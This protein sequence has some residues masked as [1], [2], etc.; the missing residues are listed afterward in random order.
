MK[1]IL[2]I[3]LLSATL[4]ALLSSCRNPNPEDYVMMDDD[5]RKYFDV[6]RSDYTGKTIEIDKK[7]EVTDEAVNA[8]I[9]EV[10]WE[11]RRTVDKNKEIAE[12]DFV[13]FYVRGE[14]NGVTLPDGDSTNY[15]TGSP[16]YATLG[17]TPM[18]EAIKNALLGKKVADYSLSRMFAGIVSK[19]QNIMISYFGY[20]YGDDG[21][22]VEYIYRDSQYVKL[23][24][25]DSKLYLSAVGET[26]G[27][28]YSYQEKTVIDGVEREV[29][30][31][32]LVDCII[33][34]EVAIEVPCTL[35][36][37]AYASDSEF[38]YLNGQEVVFY[39]IPMGIYKV[40]VLDETFVTITLEFDTEEEDIVA[41]YRQSVRDALEKEMAQNYVY[42]RVFRYFAE[43]VKPTSYPKALDLE[44]QIPKAVEE[45]LA[46]Q[47]WEKIAEANGYKS[48]DEFIRAYYGIDGDARYDAMTLSEALETYMWENNNED[49]LMCL[50]L[51]L[52]KIAATD[53]E[54]RQY[55]QDFSDRLIETDPIY[56]PEYIEY[57]YAQDY[58]DGYLR[59]LLDFDK[60]GAFLLK[61]NNIVYIENL[62]SEETAK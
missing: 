31:N 55:L 43:H 32:C 44:N 33:G 46:A 52:E 17:K 38:A 9:D 26:V 36:A 61:N 28:I 23:S 51:Q 34:Q 16:V 19:S 57:I 47:D 2:S 5:M 22:E 29:T 11:N 1:R 54:Y 21:K 37:D 39:V 53:E 12:G 4:V 7:Y 60:L 41:A 8:K 6:D 42:S 35:E 13:G 45:L 20:Y 14:Y 59:E 10:L 3:L 50:L 48:G 24:D 27:N 58:Y 15:T 30:Y 25:T 56:T 62:E 49:M 18:R 40:P